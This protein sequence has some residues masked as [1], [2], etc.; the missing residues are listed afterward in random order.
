MEAFEKCHEFLILYTQ[1]HPTINLHIYLF[2]I[3]CIY[4]NQIKLWCVFNNN[5]YTIRIIGIYTHI[6]GIYL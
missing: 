2:K 4:L 1:Q 3:L 5:V 6:I